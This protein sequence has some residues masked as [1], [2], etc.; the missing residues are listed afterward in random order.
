VKFRFV[1]IYSSAI[2]AYLS[3]NIIRIKKKYGYYIINSGNATKENMSQHFYLD[4]PLHVSTTLKL[5]SS[6]RDAVYSGRQS[7]DGGS[8]F[9]QNI[10]SYPPNNGRHI[11]DHTLK[12][13][14]SILNLLKQKILKH[15]SS[16]Q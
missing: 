10:G 8:M 12:F 11:Q 13:D 5:W 16:N 14:M 9:F 6:G 3:S 15:T 4:H 7:L 2:H 1:T